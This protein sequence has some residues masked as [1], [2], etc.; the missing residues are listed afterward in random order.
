MF[1]FK[2][3]AIQVFSISIESLERRFLLASQTF[4]NPGSITIND[5][6]SPPTQ[7]S[8]YPSSINVSGVSG[9]VTN[10]SVQLKNFGHGS[11]G[12]VDILLVN[13]K[14]DSIILMSDAGSNFSVSNKTLTFDDSGSKLPDLSQINS[15]T[16]RPTNVNDGSNDDFPD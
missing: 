14:G 12:D 11:P 16:Y 2:P 6:F 1:K 3:P 9:S 13:P 10:I 15:G 5:S 7:A 8:P 4:T